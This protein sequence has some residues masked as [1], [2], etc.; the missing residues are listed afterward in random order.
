MASNWVTLQEWR[1]YT[2]T[3][4]VTTYSVSAIEPIIPIILH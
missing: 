1:N 2:L 4:E 3:D